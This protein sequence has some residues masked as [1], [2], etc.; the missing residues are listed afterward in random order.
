M[1]RS[2]VCSFVRG[3]CIAAAVFSATMLVPGVAFAE[4]GAPP[5]VEAHFP[6]PGKEFTE[7]VERRLQRLHDR[8]EERLTKLHP[9]EDA[10]KKARD[11]YTALAAKIRGQTAKAAA[12]GSV[13]HDEAKAVRRLFRQGRRELRHAVGK[14]RH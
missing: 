12:D 13:S 11:A 1:I 5:A 7:R 8:L 2:F 4:K 10:K 14:A 6:M 9:S 3:A